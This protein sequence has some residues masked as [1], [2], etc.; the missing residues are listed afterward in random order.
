MRSDHVA[1]RLRWALA[2]LDPAP[3]DRVLEIGCGHGVAV[4]LVGSRLRAGRIVAIDRS[5]AMI[6]RATRR[7]HEL[8]AAGTAEFRAV[9]LADAGFGEERF[10]KIFAVNVRLFGDEAARESDTLGR[11]L[12]SNGSLYLFHE[13]P[14]ERRTRAATAEGVAALARAKFAVDRV[15]ETGHGGSKITC[16]VARRSG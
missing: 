5:P 9:A 13:H 3:D 11:A 16:V 7:N 8:V 1:E 6:D 15:L 12:A 10:D 4:S 2:V 14:S